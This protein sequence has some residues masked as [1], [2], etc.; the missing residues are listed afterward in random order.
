MIPTWI[1]IVIIIAIMVMAIMVLQKHS[2]VPVSA[3]RTSPV[4]WS[5]N[6]EKLTKANTNWRNVIYTSDKLQISLMSVP[7]NEE[8]GLEVHPKNDQ[9]FRIESGQGKLVI[10]KPNA[11]NHQDFLLTDGSAA[12]V[13]R[14]IWHNVINTS[15]TNPLKLYTLYGPPHHP[16]GTVDTTHT[17]EI[18]RE[19]S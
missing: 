11:A 7:P 13:P 14:G 9:F 1:I 17:E 5:D 10:G 8:L 2:E 18:S 19:K 12:V 3:K 6:I 16:L 15:T 4:V